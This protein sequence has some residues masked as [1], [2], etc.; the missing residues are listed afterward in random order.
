M[1]GSVRQQAQRVGAVQVLEFIPAS[2]RGGLR[3]GI[4]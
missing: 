1:E 4:K 3:N 2:Q